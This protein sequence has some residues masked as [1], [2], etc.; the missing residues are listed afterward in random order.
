MKISIITTN[1]NTDKYLE[2]TIKSVLNQKG[3]FKLEY[4][5]TD[6]GSTDNSLKIIKKYD[7]EIREGIWGNHVVFKVD[8]TS[9]NSLNSINTIGIREKYQD[10]VIQE[11]EYENIIDSYKT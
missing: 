6:G 10:N 4:I 11:L 2:K 8:I 7:K 5:I 1:Y 9:L 3:D